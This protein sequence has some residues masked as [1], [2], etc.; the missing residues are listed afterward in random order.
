MTSRSSICSV[1]AK[2]FPMLV[3][4]PSFGGVINPK[5]NFSH[6]L[7]SKFF[8]L[9]DLAYKLVN[10]LVFEN[11]HVKWARTELFK[12]LLVWDSTL[13]MNFKSVVCGIFLIGH[14]DIHAATQTSITTS[15]LK[16]PLYCGG[17]HLVLYSV[18]WLKLYYTILFC[19]VL[20]CGYTI[21]YSTVL[22]CGYTILY[23][24]VL[25]CGVHLKNLLLVGTNQEQVS[26][27]QAM[28]PAGAMQCNTVQCIAVQC[29]VL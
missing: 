19:T 4:T 14:T 8:F 23:S 29:S 25:Y 20:Y 27:A 22:Y 1:S 28:C 3:K 9:S 12:K 24:T 5:T 2:F 26:C 11:I 6:E 21:L 10:L 15:R 16:R 13:P 7:G 17:F 18:L